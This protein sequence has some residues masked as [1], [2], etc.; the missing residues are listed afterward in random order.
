MGNKFYNKADLRKGIDYIGVCVVFFCHDGKENLLMHKRSKNCRDEIGRWDCGSGSIEMGET[1]QE[2]ARREIKEEYGVK[3]KSLKFCG[4]N[5]ALREDYHVGFN[6]KIKTH[7][8]ALIFAAK[9]NPKK[10]KIG[11]PNKMDKIGWFKINRLPKP[12]HSMVLK[13]LSLV[14]NNK[15]KI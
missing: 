12:L 3:P 1:L 7:W 14:K 15:I 6:K 5:N 13:H 8:I 11:E 10:V 2:A 4:V 9:V